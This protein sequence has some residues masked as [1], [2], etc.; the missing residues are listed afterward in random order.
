MPSTPCPF[1]PRLWSGITGELRHLPMLLPGAFVCSSQ[2]GFLLTMEAPIDHW[3]IV[4]GDIASQ[5]RG[6]PFC[7]SRGLPYI[8]KPFTSLLREKS[9]RQGDSVLFPLAMSLLDWFLPWIPF[10]IS[11]NDISRKRILGVIPLAEPEFH[12]DRHGGMATCV[13]DLMLSS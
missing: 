12:L 2:C 8:K 9:S 5:L 13:L 7:D 1:P 6:V 11:V 4:I 3:D 10:H